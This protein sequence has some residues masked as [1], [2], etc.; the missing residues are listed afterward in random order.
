MEQEKEK[1]NNFVFKKKFG[2]NFLTDTNLLKAIVA[3][4]GIT[5]DDEV[6]EI[7]PGAGALTYE[8]ARASKKV[9]CY[10]IDKDLQPILQK[11]L[12]M[13]DNVEVIFKDILK[14]DPDEIKRHFTKPFKVVAN[15]PYYITTPIIFYFL[16]QEFNINSLTVMVQKE[17]AERLVATKS[18]KNYGT[19]T[20]SANIKSDVSITRVVSRKLFYPVPNVDSAILHFKINQNKFEVVNW[21]VLKKVVKASFAMRRKTLYNNL[22]Q[23]FSLSQETLKQ[24]LNSCNILETAR[25]ES[26]SLEEFVN[27]ANTL[28][29]LL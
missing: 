7:G 3:D 9:V 28:N 21:E 20:V 29:K 25:G 19:I 26:L 4:A 18:T 10:E 1:L 2:Q 16:E 11:K 23:A 14:V 8:L 5:K 15:L 17:V 13:F 6:L 27:L 24:A 22:K 12:S